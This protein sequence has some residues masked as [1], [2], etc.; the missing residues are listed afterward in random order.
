[1]QKTA[2]KIQHAIV[3]KGLER[4]QLEGIWLKK[5]TK[6]TRDKP[7]MDVILNGENLEAIA[8]KSEFH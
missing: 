5:I 1:M 2:D 8:V 4:A 3:I 6:A 7:A